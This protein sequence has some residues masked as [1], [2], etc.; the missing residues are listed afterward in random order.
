M[1]W[2][3]QR[4]VIGTVLLFFNPEG[5]YPLTLPAEQHVFWACISLALV[6][7]KGVPVALWG[8][9]MWRMIIIVLSR[10]MG[11]KATER[12]IS[13][14]YEKEA[15]PIRKSNS[16]IHGGPLYAEERCPTQGAYKQRLEGQNAWEHHCRLWE[17]GRGC[18][19]HQRVTKLIAEPVLMG[20]L[21]HYPS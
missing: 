14:Q 9:V 4:W 7:E 1:V 8:T 6:G 18:Q 13:V 3:F 20:F 19:Q 17:S 12:Q 5:F 2:Y 10:P 21:P 11:W 15:S 16:K